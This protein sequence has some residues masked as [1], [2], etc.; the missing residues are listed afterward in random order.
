MKHLKLFAALCCAAMLFAA[1]DKSNEPNDG[2]NNQNTENGHE[3]VD[4]GLP[5]GTL[6]ATCNVGA[7]SPEEYGDY[8][9]WGETETK[10]NYD[11]DTYKWGTA[12]YSA[13]YDNWIL[14]T[15]T[16]YNTKNNFGTVDNKT[17]L[18]PEDDAATVNWGG[19]WRMPT[20]DEWMELRENCTWT[21]VEGYNGTDKNGYEVKSKTNGKSIFLPAA[22]CRYY[23]DLDYA[24]SE[25]NY[26]SSSLY[27][28][29]PDDA[30]EVYFESDYVGR[31]DDRRYYGFSV[32]PVRTSNE[33]VTTGT[34][35]GYNWVNLGLPSG[36][37]WATCNVGATAPEAYGDYY[38]WGETT[39]PKDSYYWDTYK[40]TTD[41]GE[42][43]TQYNGSDGKTTL[44]PEDDA[45]AIN[46][47]GKWR[48][49]TDAEW[50]ELCE[51][52]TW[53][54]TTLNDVNGYEVKSKTNGNSIFLPAA[55]FCSYDDMDGT[56]DAGY[57]W[58]SSLNTGSSYDAWYVVVSKDR[59]SRVNDYRC[60]GQSVRPVF[61]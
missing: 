46:W 29:Y 40:L 36:T 15:L 21:W 51:N 59:V 25:G 56:G 4:L 20:D 33:V 48:M 43:F 42:T 44:D 60:Y 18:D 23:G 16:K 50:T 49:P 26:W 27:T 1:C 28:A 41:D 12:T 55:G 61:K 19:K 14:E 22:G 32:R 3:Y 58:S 30:W 13:E 5:S 57:Y 47:G 35:N 53:T 9:A 52:C 17:T 45:A 10:D 6:W 34:E 38:A 7:N 2:S 8:F 11:C 24:G 54:W 37:K 31:N 39:A